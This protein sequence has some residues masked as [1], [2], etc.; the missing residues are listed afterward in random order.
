MNQKNRL[1][2]NLQCQ[3]TRRSSNHKAGNQE[4]SQRKEQK[5][6]VEYCMSKN[7]KSSNNLPLPFIRC[8]WCDFQDK[9]VHDLGW[10]FYD[11]HKYELTD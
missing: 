10:H 7:N 9:K 5:G 3:T 8:L 4:Y 6:M 1:P 11:R 2:A